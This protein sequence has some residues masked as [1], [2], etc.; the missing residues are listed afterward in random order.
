MACFTFC[1][2]ALIQRTTFNSKSSSA[3]VIKSTAT[4]T[5][6]PQAMILLLFCLL[7][8]LNPENGCVKQMYFLVIFQKVINTQ[9]I[10]GLK[11]LHL[12]R[13]IKWVE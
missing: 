7:Y 1:M 9:P 6:T 8:V 4:P 13:R 5:A 11:E 3:Y 10:V 2:L 12:M